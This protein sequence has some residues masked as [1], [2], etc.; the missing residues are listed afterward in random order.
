MN[1]SKEMEATV[2]DFSLERKYVSLGLRSFVK[3]E[4]RQALWHRS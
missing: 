2:S 3:N 1:I 4:D